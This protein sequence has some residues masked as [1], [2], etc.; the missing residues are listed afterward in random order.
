MSDDPDNSGVGYCRPPAEHQFRKGQSGNPKGRP[1]KKNSANPEPGLA[2]SDSL[3]LSEARRL[4]TIVE[5]GRQTKQSAAQLVL[6]RL[7]ASAANGDVR[8]AKLAMELTQQ[9]E[10]AASQC[11]KVLRVR[12]M[13]DFRTLTH[14]QASAAYMQMINDPVD[15]PIG[16]PKRTRR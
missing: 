7:F 9:A 11:R 15:P 4:F 5:N 2:V 1:L 14:E 3:V 16:S 13:P 12:A 6:R 10:I 8:S